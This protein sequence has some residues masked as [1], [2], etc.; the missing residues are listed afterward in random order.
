[1]RPSLLERTCILDGESSHEATYSLGLTFGYG[2]AQGH[3]VGWWMLGKEARGKLF[4]LSSPSAQAYLYS[5]RLPHGQETCTVSPK[6]HKPSVLG[7]RVTTTTAAS[8]DDGMLTSHQ[9][10]ALHLLFPP[11]HVSEVGTVS[12]LT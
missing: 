8:T 7:V 6:F 1:M 10:M 4:R 9:G 11:P 3:R 2:L 12:V 5:S